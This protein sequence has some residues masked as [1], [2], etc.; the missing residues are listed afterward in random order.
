M[1]TIEGAKSPAFHTKCFDHHG[2]AC[3]HNCQ[4]ERNYALK[5]ACVSAE[6]QEL[7]QVKVK[8]PN[9]LYFCHIGFLFKCFF[10]TTQKAFVQSSPNVSQM[11]IGLSLKKVVKWIFDCQKHS[12]M[13][14]HQNWRLR[15]AL[16][17]K[18]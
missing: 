13:T 10:A 6:E 17:R 7:G 12:T 11:I 5:I 15:G 18:Q 2:T 9:D 4:C 3:G 1:V 14:S 8:A 16:W